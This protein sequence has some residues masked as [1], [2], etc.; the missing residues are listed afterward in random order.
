MNMLLFFILKFGKQMC[1][2]A[3]T[4]THTQSCANVN[5]PTDIQQI[6]KT[7]IVYNTA[8]RKKNYTDV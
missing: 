1:A 8:D 5:Q 7:R 4:H 6:N 2:H 3:H